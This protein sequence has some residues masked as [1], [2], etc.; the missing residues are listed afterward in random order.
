LPSNLFKLQAPALGKCMLM[1]LQQEASL[2][3]VF[4]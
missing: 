2:R 3:Q 4:R 1:D